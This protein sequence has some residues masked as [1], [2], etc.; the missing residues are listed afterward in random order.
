MAGIGSIVGTV[1]RSVSSWFGTV[2][3]THP[4]TV[5]VADTLRFPP[6]VTP[7]PPRPVRGPS[8]RFAN[9]DSLITSESD[10]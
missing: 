7:A 6:S 9:V 3:V 4:L 10:H 2:G 5:S 1:V 8:V